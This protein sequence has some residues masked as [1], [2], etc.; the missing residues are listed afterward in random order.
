[1]GLPVKFIL[2]EVIL[3]VEVQPVG[4]LGLQLGDVG[5]KVLDALVRVPQLPGFVIEMLQDELFDPGAIAVDVPQDPYRRT[6][7]R[8]RGPPTL[9][10]QRAKKP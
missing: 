4:A 10:R 9:G 7:C 8:W 6:C 2:G 3:K 1:M 5:G